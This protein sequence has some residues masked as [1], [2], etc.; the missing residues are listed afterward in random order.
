MTFHPTMEEFK[1]FNKY[2]A[3]MESQGA[4]RAGLAKVIPPKEWRPRQ[5][6]EDIGDILI[7]TP[8][9]QKTFGC[10]GVFNQFHEEKEAM[11]VEEYRHLANSEKYRTPAHLDLEDLERRYWQNRPYNPPVYGA[12]VSGSLFD[13]GTEEWNLGKLG[14]LQPL[15]EQ[16]CGVVT[17][18]LNTP[19]LHFGMWKTTLAWHTEDMD[20]Y[21]INYLHLGAPR[22][23]YAVPPEHGRSLERLASRLFPASFR[24]CEAF[25]RHKVALI[26]P[27]VLRGHGIP[28]QRI[29]QEAGQFMVTFPSGY[30][31]GFNHGFNCAEAINFATPRW[32]D[33]GKVAS[34]CRCRKARLTCS[35]EP[36]VWLLQ[37]KRYELWKRGLDQ[38]MV[39]PKEPS[40]P[41]GLQL[42]ACREAGVSARVEQDG[43]EGHRVP[44]R[45]PCPPC[46]LPPGRGPHRWGPVHLPSRIPSMAQGPALRSQT[47]PVATIATIAATTAT[48]T[49]IATTTKATTTAA[50]TTTIATTTMT[51]ATMATATATTTTAAT[52]TGRAEQEGSERHHAPGRVPCPPCPLPLGGGPYCFVS[53]NPAPSFPSVTGDP[54]LPT[55]PNQESAITLGST[56]H[57]P[58]QSHQPPTDTKRAHVHR[59]CRP[60]KSA[61]QHLAEQR[62]AKRTKVHIM[63][64]PEAQHL[65]LNPF[66]TGDSTLLSSELQNPAQKSGCCCALDLQPLGPPLDPEN[67]MHPG[68]CLRSLD[69][70]QVHFSAIFLSP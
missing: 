46:P 35:M 14:T 6:Y 51:T 15:L 57:S 63:L 24:D 21:S 53:S 11:S 48:A 9:Q 16:E 42:T 10:A 18:G 43:C 32:V 23:W 7:A 13:E 29:T 12:D 30:H 19:S 1:D 41:R 31:A 8:V 67:P 20:L 45:V 37:P 55:A 59:C 47:A 65:P 38:V 2:I 25:L 44:S 58:V 49:T 70:I 3:Y 66:S 36:F 22:T 64:G 28:F 26:S 50:A 68:P 52:T 5:I 62:P 39:E 4:H 40:A 17:A 33:Y 56:L 27:G 60:R 34:Q 54:V 61:A 69:D